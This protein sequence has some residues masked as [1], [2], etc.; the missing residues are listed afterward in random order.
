YADYVARRFG[1]T[2]LVIFLAVTINF[3]IPRLAPGDPIE[4]QLNQLLASG[5]G[6]A[7]DVQAMVDSY[8]ARFGLDQPVWLQYLAYWQSVLRFD[9]GFSLANY[10]ERVAQSILAGLPWTLGLLGFAT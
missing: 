5:G 1:I 9:L 4:A 7:G 2:L 3:V 6:A 10:P 8:R